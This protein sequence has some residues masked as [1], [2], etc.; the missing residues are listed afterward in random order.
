MGAFKYQALDQGGRTIE[1][2]MEGD[3]PRQ[4]R[5]SLRERGMTPLRVEAI[6][7]GGKRAGYRFRRAMSSSSLAAVTRQFA[8]LIHAGLTIEECLAALVEQADSG[9][10]KN[11]LIALRGRVLE[12]QSLSSAMAQ[13]PSAFPLL[14][15]RMVEAGEQSGRLDEVL[16]RLADYT[17]N[18]QVLL[19]KVILALVYPALLTLV[20]VGVVTGLLIS[21]VPQVVRVFLNTG[22]TLPYSTRL[23]IRISALVRAPAPWILAIA[24][25]SGAAWAG[26]KVPS[27]R[28][29][30][31]RSILKVPVLGR[32]LRGINSTRFTSTLSI[33]IAS[34]IPLLDAMQYAVQ[35]IENIPMRLA[36]EKA[37]QQVSEG[38]SLSQ[39]LS[40]SKLF[41]PLLIHLIAS[42]EKSG[43]LAAMLQRAARSQSKELESW[44]SALTA[45]LEPLLILVMGGVVL[46]IVLAILSPIIQMNQLVH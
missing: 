28:R 38:K 37:L 10:S 43:R 2:V 5:T 41:P 15:L 30:R 25:L 35:V 4:I 46:F 7:P 45:L 22:Q 13:F 40:E 31:Q 34:G 21:V 29:W 14:Y 11:V 20:A 16:E 32:L 8:T 26:M 27:A 39:S 17:E 12:G 6:H 9:R 3:L 18:R 1:G 44:A 24:A 23:L 36:T 19:Q 42:G 33:L